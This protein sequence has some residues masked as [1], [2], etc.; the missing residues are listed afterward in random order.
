[1]IGWCPR[2]QVNTRHLVEDTK[3]VRIETC[4]KCHLLISKFWKIIKDSP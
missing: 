4:L 3:I 1:M 2:C